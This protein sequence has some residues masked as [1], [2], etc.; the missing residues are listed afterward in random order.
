MTKLGIRLQIFALAGTLL[1]MT[2]AVTALAFVEIVQQG[3]NLRHTH[4]LFNQAQTVGNLKEDFTQAHLAA[5]TTLAGDASRAQQVASNLEEVTGARPRIAETFLETE[6]VA[7]QRPEDAEILNRMV[8]EAELYADTF[9]RARTADGIS[10]AGILRN[11]LAPA[12]ERIEARL[13]ALQNRLQEEVG[14]VEAAGKALA[15][16]VKRI[17][18]AGAALALLTGGLIAFAMG[19]QLSRAIAGAADAVTRIGGGDHHSDVPGAARGDEIG[20]ISRNLIELRDA[21]RQ[22]EEARAAERRAEERRAALFSELGEKL[23]ALAGGDLEKRIA[24]E[25]YDDLGEMYRALCED[26]NALG[27]SFAAL[28]ASVRAS[29]DTVRSGASEMAQGAGDLSRRSESQAATLEQSAAALDELTASVK[30]AAEKAAEA[31]RSV[32]ETRGQAQASGEVVRSAVEAMRDI[33]ESSGQITQIIGV[34]DDI[35]FQT[36]LLALNAGVEAARAGEAGRGFA[37]V[38]SEVRALAQRASDSAQEIKDLISKS[39]SQ[40]EEG[41]QL[42][43]KTGTA[44]E[45]I[46]ERVGGVADLVADIAT[47]AREQSVGLQQINTGVNELDQV[48]QQNVAVIEEATAASQQ[49]NNEAGKLTDALSRFSTAAGEGDI[50]VRAGATGTD[51]RMARRPAAPEPKLVAVAGGGSAEPHATEGWQDF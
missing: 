22:A 37:V 1:A 9:A 32:A 38:A 5:L 6:R 43:G 12:Y 13:D 36:N 31:D 41:A 33:E 30:S 27:E 50:G 28:I 26:F 42:V 39:A 48:T 7:W 18:L 24:P 3:K 34:I 44:L 17:M 10:R 45:E 29:A 15:V 11:Q 25:D 40:V 47:S 8:K 19:R 14:A 49:L 51:S 16:K 21:L 23:S 46:V 4:A 2:V 20:T 35:A